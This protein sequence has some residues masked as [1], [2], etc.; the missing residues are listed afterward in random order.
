MPLFEFEIPETGDH[1]SVRAPDEDTARAWVVS[2]VYHDDP[3]GE[4][5]HLYTPEEAEQM[6]QVRAERAAALRLI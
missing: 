4:D 2:Q 5:D 6:R 1:Q 3:D